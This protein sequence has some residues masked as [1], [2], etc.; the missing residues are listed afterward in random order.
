MTKN[1]QAEH[2]AYIASIDASIDEL[3]EQY[4]KDRGEL[5]KTIAEAI[6]RA[7]LEADISVAEVG[8]HLNKT[9]Q[10]VNRYLIDVYGI[11][12]AEKAAAAKLGHKQKIGA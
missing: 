4:K 8:K 7:K 5:K 9:R 2:L 10:T 11:R 3:D 1:T 6:T 12:H